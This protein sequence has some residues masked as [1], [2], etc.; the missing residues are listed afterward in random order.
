ML[1]DPIRP[2]FTPDPSQK[3]VI[4]V[5]G[6]YHLVLAPPG[7]GKTQILT[8]RIRTAHDQR[9][10]DY[11]DMLCLTFTN[12]AARGMRER[13]DQYISDTSVNDVFVGNVHRFCARFLFENSI[14]PASTSIIDEDDAISIL[15]RYLT[16]DEYLVKVNSKRRR[17]YA[18]VFHFE[19]FIHQVRKHHPRYL[20]THPDCLTGDDVHALKTI[21][22]IQKMEFTPEVMV[23][24]FEHTDTYLTLAQS[25]AY[26]YG[27]QKMISTLLRKM[28]LAHH[29]H[30]Y[31]RENHLVDFEDLLVLAY[32]ALSEGGEG[33]P[34]YSW[35]QVDEVQDLSPIQMAIVDLL[36]RK[37]DAVTV[38]YLGDEQQ[39]IFSFMGA[40]MDTLQMLK[41][42][43][44]DNIHHLSTNHRSP[45]YLLEVYNCYAEQ[46]L[47]QKLMKVAEPAPSS[48]TPS[49][50]GVG[51]RLIL[52]SDTFDSEVAEVVA[53]A[54]AFYEENP[55]ATTA[56]IVSSNS[57]ADRLSSALNEIHLR[58]FKVSGED[59]FAS[60]EVKLLLA[61]LN[62]LSNDHNFIAWARLL[63]GL[64]VCQSNA[65]ARNFV[66][67]SLDAAIL[68]SDYLLYDGSTY[69]QE[70]VRSVEEKE[71][72]VFDT[73]TT[74]LNVFEDDIVQIAAVKLRGGH[75][76]KGSEFCVFLDT[77]REIPR[78]LGDLDNPLI[79]ALQHNV[80]VPRREGL[81][82]FVEYVGDAVLLAHNAD[83][84]IHIL[85]HNLKAFGMTCPEGDYIDSL[86]LARLL[87]PGLLSHKLKYLLEALHLEG[88]NSHMADDDVA[89][90]VSV[91]RHCYERGR[92]LV[93]AQRR[94]LSQAKVRQRI[95]TLRRRYSE[96]FFR[97]RSLLYLR[98][99][100]PQHRP[101]LVREMMYFYRRLLDDGLIQ[102]IGNI[103]YIERFLSDDIII[104]AEAPSLAE[105]L[106]RHLTEIN[107]LKEADLCS[108][109]TIDD[110][111]FVTT[112][113]KAK[114]LEFDNVIVFDA[115]D[116]RYP[117]FYSKQN[118]QQ[119]AE[120]ARKFYVAMSRAKRRLVI[121]SSLH[122]IDYYNQLRPR[123]L[124][125][126]M[127]PIEHF[128]E[129]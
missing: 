60:A 82:R 94:F 7:C 40:K 79:E 81:Q 22:R 108:S 45:G 47:H 64:G 61:H 77:D 70:F 3:V 115:V 38:V 48:S 49:E 59:L 69:V 104:Q 8:E 83:F 18:E 99:A 118:P 89:A 42:R 11:S 98:E 71:I 74:G 55:D 43:C 117:N 26:D 1:D 34:S 29:Y 105:Q 68:P 111:I 21:C 19:T 58:H 124:T 86:K 107:T 97:S 84:D 57:D 28:T 4:D 44:G 90:T 14:V 106:S 25:D 110:R 92:Q 41:E 30:C 63:R 85:A 32:D 36:T 113:H 65:Y 31:K 112:V 96:F 15:A 72:V 62:V 76:V 121:A 126:F 119:L 101:V 75:V 17:E 9:H 46:V 10:V 128:F 87:E 109:H 120:D 116:G 54:K 27:S 93:E 33:L 52:R 53:M 66:Q 24:I 67:A 100:Q 127:R 88:T 95:E 103:S 50:S 5:H 56:L 125:P 114:G 51:K 16:E 80:Q 91:V 12:R 102:P 6:G 73:E 13:I 122:Y 123:E 37:D 39:A 129:G 20:R 2:T 78:K 23:D 35:I